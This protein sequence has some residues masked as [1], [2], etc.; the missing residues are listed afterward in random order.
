MGN[1]AVGWGC[2]CRDFLLLWVFDKKLSYVSYFV[3]AFTQMDKWTT[4]HMHKWSNG[5]INKLENWTV[6]LW[7]GQAVYLS[8]CSFCSLSQKSIHLLG[9]LKSSWQQKT[10]VCGET[11]YCLCICPGLIIYFCSPPPLT[12]AGWPTTISPLC[13]E[14]NALP[15][16][17]DRLKL[18]E[19]PYQIL[20]CRGLR[21][22]W[23][24]S[25]W[26]QMDSS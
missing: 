23:G 14:S 1:P 22:F 6:H 7:W 5:K 11:Q 20:V 19:P 9:G 12:P 18:A 10:D 21:P 4:G 13:H 16:V 3:F 24:A 26:W 8:I 2:Y 15:W 17:T 25:D